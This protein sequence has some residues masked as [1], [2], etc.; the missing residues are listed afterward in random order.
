MLYNLDEVC[1]IP[2]TL[3]NVESRSQCDPTY[4]GKLPVYI[5]PMSSL[6][7][8]NNIDNFNE[9]GFQTILPRSI[10]FSTRIEYM[11]KGFEIAV[12]LKEAKILYNIFENNKYIGSK[13]RICIDQANGHMQKLLDIC[14]D[15]KMLMGVGGI[16]IT[17]GNIANPATYYEYAKVGIDAV[18]IGIGSGNVCTTSLQTGIHYPMASLIHQCNLAKDFIKKSLNINLDGLP[19]HITGSVKDIKKTYKSIPLIIADGG[20]NR[21]DQIVKAL[22][23]GADYVMLGKMIAKMDEACG[24]KRV[25][26]IGGEKYE[27]REYYG[28]STERAQMLIKNGSVVSVENIKMS[29]G[30]IKDVI[31]NTNINIFKKSLIH[32]LKSS[33]SYVNAYTL[34]EFVG[35]VNWEV[36]NKNTLDKS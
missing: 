2:A 17:T 7:D 14:N 33:M 25:K 15:L 35:K 8:E 1:L 29:E 20:F 34:N 28:M 24:Q 31:I 27:C 11:K 12:G 6:I 36:M 26:W 22:A 9:H 32:A 10:P 3:T 30:T 16:W 19:E 23:L 13:P 5:A 18:R 21:F 4:N